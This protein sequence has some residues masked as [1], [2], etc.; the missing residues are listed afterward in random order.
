MNLAAKHSSACQ[1]L[2]NEGA[3]ADAVHYCL[4]QGVLPPFPPCDRTSPDY[5]QCAELAKET[6]SDYGWWEKRLKLRDA[7]A[8]RQG[9]RSNV[10]NG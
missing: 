5:E 7:R 3:L 1:E 8:A 2:M 9:E 6:L 10:E 4:A